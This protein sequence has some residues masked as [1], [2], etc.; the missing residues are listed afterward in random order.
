MA[1]N[2][3]HQEPDNSTVTDWHGQKVDKMMEDAEDM[4]AEGVGSDV[5]DPQTDAE[6]EFNAEKDA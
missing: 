1:E 4:P 2:D 3:P 6:A 5:A